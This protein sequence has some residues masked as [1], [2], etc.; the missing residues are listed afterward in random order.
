MPN[1]LPILLFLF[2]AVLG[3]AANFLIY[4]QRLEPRPISPWMPSVPPMSRRRWF[5]FVPIFGWLSLRR[6]ASVFGAGFWIRPLLVELLMAAGVASLYQFEIGGGLLPIGFPRPLTPFLW[7]IH[8]QSAAHVIL[9]FWM[10]VAALID[11]DETII[12]DSVIIPGT[13]IG[14]ACAALLPQSMLPNAYV[15]ALACWRL[16][17][18]WLSSPNRWPAEL[19]PPGI[20]GLLCGL[21]C[22]LLWCFALLPRTWYSRH[23]ARRALSLCLARVR[24]DRFSLLIAGLAIVGG[25]A[26]AVCWH[27]GGPHWQGLLSALVGMA[28]GAA[29]IWAV[30]IVG[31]AAMK[32]EAMGFGD[33]TLMAM[34][35][36]FLGW[37]ATLVVF[38]LAPFAA[39]AYGL[40][41]LFSSRQREIAYGPFL[42]PAALATIIFW[43]PIW[44][45]TWNVFA[46]GWL[47]PLIIAACVPLIP[48]MLYGWRLIRGG[49]GRE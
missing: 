34:I 24:R 27:F 3:A 19:N 21:A 32:R 18:L 39:L 16:D 28:G 42:C 29:V 1:L 37:Q 38:F 11:A 7:T 9:I 40:F 25:A 15:D 35:G 36:A 10:T 49:L 8:C 46:L 31:S 2:G 41:R 44:D 23:G 45:R 26:I 4:W 33:V 43:D 12:P 13:L 48:L 6:E 14:L 47:V 5:D 20:Y 30:R 17:P 22:W